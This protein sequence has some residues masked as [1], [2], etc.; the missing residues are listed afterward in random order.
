MLHFNESEESWNA[1]FPC[2]KAGNEDII[3][4]LFS[5]YTSNVLT[6][7]QMFGKPPPKKNIFIINPCTFKVQS[8]VGSVL[9]IVGSWA[10]IWGYFLSFENIIIQYCQ[11][12]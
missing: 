12:V 6:L 1:T 4:L 9:E 5:N 7:P 2:F 3:N 10:Q 8:L 11:C